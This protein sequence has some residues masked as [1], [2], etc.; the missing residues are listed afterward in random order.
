MAETLDYMVLFLFIF[1][2]AVGSFVNVLADRWSIGESILGR[3]HCD[4]CKKKIV[5]YDLIPVLSF[6]L[7]RARCRNCKR[8]I[9]IQCPLVEIATAFTF[10]LVYKIHIHTYGLEIDPIRLVYQFTIV[11]SLIVIFVADIKY[12][13][14]PDEANIAIGLSAVL[15]TL[16]YTPNSL[17]SHFAGALMAAGLFLILV[18]VTSGKG[19]GVG[20]VKYV[21]AAG[22][23]L[24]FVKVVMA[25]YLAFLTGAIFSLILILVGAKTMKSTIAFGPFLT[26]ATFLTF[27]Y[28]SELWIVFKGVLGI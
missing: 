15:F 24:G 9:S 16:I 23:L 21:F 28:G 4:H 13:I 18:I 19:M 6:I 27:L 22:L 12:R 20:D 10:L 26:A 7:L 14:I 5:W 17:I 25:L 1:G 11:S 8:K 3:S 2:L